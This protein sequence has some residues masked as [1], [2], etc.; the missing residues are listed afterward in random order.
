M[1]LQYS[2]MGSMGKIWIDAQDRF[3]EFVAL[4]AKHHGH[5]TEQ[6]INNGLLKG[7]TV[8]YGSKGCHASSLRDFDSII[9]PPKEKTKPEKR[10]LCCQECGQ[11]GH[12]GNYPFSTMASSSI[13]DD[14]L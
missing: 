11:T 14:C 12:R 5:T 3:D 4:A 7:K 10:V 13:C 8:S 2:A 6:I 9:A 1:K